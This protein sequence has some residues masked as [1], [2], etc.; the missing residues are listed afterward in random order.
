MNTSL[1]ILCYPNFAHTLR[2][3][4]ICQ[5]EQEV[6]STL[7]NGTI[8]ALTFATMMVS[9]AVARPVLHTAMAT[10]TRGRRMTMSS[11]LSHAMPELPVDVVKYSQVPKPPKVFTANTIPRG[12]LKQHSTKKG[13]WGIINVSKGKLEY[14]IDEPTPHKFDLNSTMKGVIVPTVLHQVR[15]LTDD[16]EFVVEFYRLPGTGPVDEKREGIKDT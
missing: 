11:S 4:K 16:V 14:Q 5:R 8:L 13:T 12:L 2:I 6:M 3:Q 7:S 15:P 1:G 9:F 10:L